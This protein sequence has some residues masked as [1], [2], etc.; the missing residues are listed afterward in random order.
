MSACHRSS[1]KQA[2]AFVFKPDGVP[3]KWRQGEMGGGGGEVRLV[4]FMFS[5]CPGLV[6]MPLISKRRKV[7]LPSP[8]R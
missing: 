8:A 2:P 7:S 6:I 5:N 1:V 3:T 4:I